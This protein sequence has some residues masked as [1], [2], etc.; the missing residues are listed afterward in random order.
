MGFFLLCSANPKS[1][2]TH[3]HTKEKSQKK[4][5]RI[6]D[7][8]RRHSALYAAPVTFAAKPL[9]R[10]LRGEATQRCAEIPVFRGRV[11]KVASFKNAPGLSEAE[12]R[13]FA[14][15]ITIKPI[16]SSCEEGCL[17]SPPLHG[18]Q[19]SAPRLQAAS[20]CELQSMLSEKRAR[21]RS[22]AN[23]CLGAPT[24]CSLEFCCC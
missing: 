2:H 9:A 19:S 10:T 23:F 21:A 5:Q 6:R 17:T 7:G 1:S 13:N 4:L 18:P 8:G 22:E 15:A 14:H 20:F 16:S 3:T 11:L 12:L 24:A